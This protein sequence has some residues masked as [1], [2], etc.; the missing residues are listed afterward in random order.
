MAW[1]QTSR[2]CCAEQYLIW[3][4][5]AGCEAHTAEISFRPADNSPFL[6]HCGLL[7][8]LSGLKLAID[9]KRGVDPDKLMAKLYKLTP[10]ED[11]F[12]CNFN[13]LIAGSPKVLGVRQILEEWTAWRT[14][15]VKRRIFFV[16][17]KKKEKLHL[18]KGNIR[19]QMRCG[20]WMSGIP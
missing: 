5:A 19:N 9:L 16:L 8:D 11:A 2:I 7:A 4:A 20:R 3:Y 10:L 12:A 18:L 14:D 6:R 17:G 13:V 15:S 1:S